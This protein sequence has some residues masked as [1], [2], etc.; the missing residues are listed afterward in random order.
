[1]P[2]PKSP[3]ARP[4]ARAL[5]TFGA[6]RIP[7]GSAVLMYRWPLRL[8]PSSGWSS[9]C[10]GTIRYALWTSNLAMTVPEP[11]DGTTLTA[12][13]TDVYTVQ[14]QFRR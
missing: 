8:I 4:S 5:N 6:D 11:D 14:A 3:H 7:K 12:S 2:F 1:M 13:S 10:T 9:G